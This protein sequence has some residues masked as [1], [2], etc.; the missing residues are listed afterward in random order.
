MA[1]LPTLPVALGVSASVND[2]PGDGD[3]D[4]DLVPVVSGRVSFKSRL[5]STLFDV[6]GFERYVAQTELHGQFDENG[7][8]RWPHRVEIQTG[9]IP[10]MRVV[11]LTSEVLPNRII[12]GATHTVTIS[13]AKTADGISVT[14]P[15]GPQGVRISPDQIDPNTG[16]INLAKL[17]P[18]PEATIVRVVEGVKGDQ[19]DKGDPGDLAPVVRGLFFAGTVTLDDYTRST[20]L[21]AT[22]TGNVTLTLPTPDADRGFTISLALTQDDT[23]GRTLTIPGAAAAY[24]V[25]VALTPSPG[26]LD[27][28]HLLWDGT[29]WITLPAAMSIGSA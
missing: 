11:D 28:V 9:G 13:D 21:H 6:D 4:P 14:F 29:R 7:W 22:L 10:H 16:V 18:A 20:I 23:G 3:A 8:V 17:M 12:E 26:A 1:N 25:P 5:P 27:L 19:G 15:D 24:G 2:K